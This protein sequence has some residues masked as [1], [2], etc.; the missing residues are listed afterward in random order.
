MRSSRLSTASMSRRWATTSTSSREATASR[1]TRETAASRSTPSTTP[2]RSTYFR[3]SAVRSVRRT[4]SSST[5]GTS[6][7]RSRPTSWAAARRCRNPR[8]AAASSQWAGWSLVGSTAGRSAV[9]ATGPSTGATRSARDA[10]TSSEY[11][12]VP[13]ATSTANST[14]GDLTTGFATRLTAALPPSRQAASTAAFVRIV[15]TPGAGSPHLPRMTLGYGVPHTTH[16]R[17][18][19]LSEAPP[20]WSGRRR[21]PPRTPAR[22]S[23][24]RSPGARACP[25]TRAWPIPNDGGPGHQARTARRRT[26]GRGRPRSASE[27]IRISSRLSHWDTTFSCTLCGRCVEVSR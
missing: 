26:A 10:A 17:T 3:T 25:A 18:V 6:S 2:S 11:A 7:S 20:R 21:R 1:S 16:G 12:V 13:T 8:R 24:R 19:R 22:P 15:R 23:A 14:T 27:F 4:T 5:A 9:L